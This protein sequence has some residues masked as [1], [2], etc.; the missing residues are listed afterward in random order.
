AYLFQQ[1]IIASQWN[2]PGELCSQ[3][4]AISTQQTAI[5]GKS[6]LVD[7][8]S[9]EESCADAAPCRCLL[10]ADVGLL[11][12]SHTV[13][14][15][16]RYGSCQQKSH[17]L[18]QTTL[19]TFKPFALPSGNSLHADSCSTSSVSIFKHLILLW[20]FIVIHPKILLC[21]LR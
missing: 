13:V 12:T 17:F 6:W 14:V 7:D 8:T 3:R 11:H 2:N 4:S 21:V 20:I 1:R 10:R 18:P 15:L 5:P 9:T 19:C 16:Y